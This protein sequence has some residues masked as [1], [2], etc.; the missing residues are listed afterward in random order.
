[1]ASGTISGEEFPELLNAIST[2]NWPAFVADEQCA[3]PLTVG[4][5]YSGPACTGKTIERASRTDLECT[6]PSTVGED[7][8]GEVCTG[9]PLH[10]V[11]GR[12]AENYSVERGQGFRR[13]D[14]L[15]AD[16]VK[17]ELDLQLTSA[18]SALGRR[19]GE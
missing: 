7:Y 16:E 13:S 1:M 18:N 5:D 3:M 19:S 12:K 17:I 11:T 15:V 9:T 10:V 8:A 2:T 14:E 6:M 4:E